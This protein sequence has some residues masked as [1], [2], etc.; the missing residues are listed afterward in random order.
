VLA[1]SSDLRVSPLSIARTVAALYGFEAG[2]RDAEV[3]EPVLGRAEESR[4]AASP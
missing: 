2:A 3:L 1:G 4:K